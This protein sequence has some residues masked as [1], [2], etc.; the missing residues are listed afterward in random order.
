MDVIKTADWVIDLG[1]EGGNEGGRVIASGTPEDVA[2][3]DK[4]F[5]GQYLARMLTAR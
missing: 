2:R 4:S 1:P 5:T 3:Q